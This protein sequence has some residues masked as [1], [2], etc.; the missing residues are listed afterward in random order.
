MRRCC[1]D[2]LTWAI[3]RDDFSEV[4]G[5]EIA[6]RWC[7]DVLLRQDGNWITI[8]PDQA[9]GDYADVRQARYAEILGKKP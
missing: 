5:T 8:P 3:V 6:C 2:T 7:S 1:K 4:E 9:V